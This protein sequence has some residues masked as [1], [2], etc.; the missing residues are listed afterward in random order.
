MRRS[1]ALTRHRSSELGTP[2]VEKKCKVTPC[3]Y[4]V[5]TSSPVR[6]RAIR[7]VHH[8]NRSTSTQIKEEFLVSEQNCNFEETDNLTLVEGSKS[9]APLREVIST[10]AYSRTELYKLLD[11]EKTE[12]TDQ[13][14]TKI[15]RTLLHGG[16]SEFSISVAEETQKSTDNRIPKAIHC[17][18]KA[19]LQVSHFTFHELLEF[20]YMI[21]LPSSLWAVH[22]QP[23]DKYI[24][25]VHV[26]FSTGNGFETDRGVVFEGTCKPII[27]FYG[28]KVPL[29]QL[30]NEVVCVGDV[31]NLLRELDQFRAVCLLAESA[32]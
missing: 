1:R 28:H 27:F 22:K 25:F 31:S 32:E 4:D 17:S 21:P 30:E 5:E 8:K 6:K 24:A 11:G 29:P 9:S 12:S 18:P 13:L 26:T 23:R 14:T 7:T 16:E 2:S 15:Q 20:A 10:S 19:K 3:D